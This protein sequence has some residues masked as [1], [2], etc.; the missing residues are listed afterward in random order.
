MMLQSKASVPQ[1]F[2][3]KLDSVTR[4]FGTR[5]VFADVCGEVR[6]GQAMVIAGPNGSGKSTL[7]R[8]AVG[9]LPSTSGQVLITNAGSDFDSIERRALLGYVAPDLSLY[10]ELTGAENLR[11]FARV[12]GLSPS[13]EELR[14]LLQRVGLEGRGRDQ[15]GN[16][17]SGMKQRLKYAF[18]L[19]HRPP[20]LFLDEP[21][22]NLDSQGVE[23]AESI[24]REQK[25][26]GVVVIATNET[27]EVTW[28]DT[29]VRLDPT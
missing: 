5:T 18:A 15:V 28:G 1:S 29:V 9:L 21:T 11:F 26:H 6:G 4:R 10:A 14:S 3:V 23:M 12:R 19:L 24:V 20:I 7:L 16:Y 13:V 27:R 22:A 2:T 25:Q 17:S 8:I